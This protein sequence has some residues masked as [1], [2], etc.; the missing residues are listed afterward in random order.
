MSADLVAESDTGAFTCPCGC[1]IRTY[2]RDRLHDHFGSDEC[3]FW[4]KVFNGEVDIHD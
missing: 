2:S 1:D 3:P 4:Q